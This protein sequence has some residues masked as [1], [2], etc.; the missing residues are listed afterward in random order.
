MAHTKTCIHRKEKNSVILAFE[1]SVRAA[2]WPPWSLRNVRHSGKWPELLDEIPPA[3]A[4]RESELSDRDT[5]LPG[6]V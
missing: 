3:R 4:G 5:V 6:Q 1:Y 2:T